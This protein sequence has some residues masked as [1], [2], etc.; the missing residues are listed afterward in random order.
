MLGLN[1]FSGDIFARNAAITP[2]TRS[3][4]TT[5]VILDNG[6]NQTD[7]TNIQDGINPNSNISNTGAAYFR[8]IFTAVIRFAEKLMIPIAIV[9]LTFAAVVLLAKKDN[10]EEL[11]KRVKQLIFMFVGFGVIMLSFTIV[12]KMFFGVEGE[13]LHNDSS[14]SFA[15]I[16][17]VEIMG[18][19]KFLSTF[20]VAIAVFFLVLGAV[21]LIIAGENEEQKGKATKTI[22]FAIIGITVIFL[23]YTIVSLF[24]GT[25]SGGQLKGLDLANMAIEITKWSNILLGF[26][27]FFAVVAIIWAGVRLI[28]HFGDEEAV[29][30]AKKIVTY[31]IIGMIL[32]FSAWTIIKFVALPGAVG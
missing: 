27:V 15:V 20:A 4:Y 8:N 3:I 5:D 12:D 25:N 14:N 18:I 19:V 24:F 9:F 1:F 23:M 7:F 2:D 13:I 11:K 16:G 10:E 31:A 22:I 32:A 17:R 6:I 29:T 30:S 26:V 28:T 21:R